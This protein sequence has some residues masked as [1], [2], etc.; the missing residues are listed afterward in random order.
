MLGD[1]TVHGHVTEKSDGMAFEIGHD[2]HGVYTRTSRSEK[3]RRVGDYT[4]AAKAKFGDSMDPTI[5][6]HFDDI[7]HHLTSNPNLTKHLR[8]TGGSIK[9]ELYHRPQGTPIGP[10]HVRFV[11]TAYDT[12][13]MGKHGSFIVHSR[14]P[15]NAS[16]KVSHVHK[17]GDDNFKFDHDHV[18][19]DIHIPMHDLKERHAAINTDILHSRKKVDA[20]HKDIE[21]RKFESIK[22]EIHKRVAAHTAKVH[23]KWGPETEG[24]VIH[25]HASNPDAPRVKIVDGNFM[26]RKHATAKFVKEGMIEEGGNVH[27]GDQKTVPIDIKDRDRKA[28]DVQEFM[29][30]VNKHSGHKIFGKD[31]KSL[32]TGS[33]WTGS[34]VHMMNHKLSSHELAK[35]KKS[36]GDVDVM[37]PHHAEEHVVKAL[38]PGTKHG[39]F[40][41]QGVK[42]IGAQHSA[43]VKHE[44]GQHHQIDFEYKDHEHGEPT[45]FARWSQNSHLHDLKTG[46]KGVMH[47]H[48]LNSITS[49]HSTH[50]IIETTKRKAIHHEEGEARPHTFAPAYGLRQK[51]EPALDAAGKQRHEGGLPVFHE[52]KPAEV[53]Y[54]TDLH[55]IH[56]KLFHKEASPVDID[57]M[58]SFHGTADLMKKHLSHDQIHKTVHSFVNKLYGSDARPH[59]DFGQKD[60]AIDSLKNHFPDHFDAPMKQHIKASKDAF[61][62]KHKPI[63]IGEAVEHPQDKHIAM[64]AGRFTGPTVEHQKLIDNVLKQKVDHHYVFVMGPADH[65]KTTEKDP[66]TVHE[67][68]HHLKKLY[69]EHKHIFVPGTTVHTKTPASALSWIHFRHKDQAKHLHL[70][71]VAGQGEEGVEKNAGGSIDSYKHMVHRLNHTK[72]PERINDEGKKVGGDHRMDYKST[73]FVPQAR[74]NVSG[75]KLRK[76]AREHDHNDPKHV[77]EFKKM[78]HTGATHEHASEIMHQIKSFKQHITE[79]LSV[80]EHRRRMNRIQRSQQKMHQRHKVAATRMATT[81]V[82]QRRAN[83]AALTTFRNHALGSDQSYTKLSVGQKL[84]FDEI[85]KGKKE[86]IA[87]LASSLMASGKQRQKEHDR[88]QAAFHTGPSQKRISRLMRS[89]NVASEAYELVAEEAK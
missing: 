29:H 22:D 85:M 8:H 70:H 68:I 49:A 41:V 67:K 21:K 30:S 80:G 37:V 39:K 46:L 12:R 58:H 44:D 18:D 77:S 55:S 14:L 17:L 19:H 6:K 73:N 59:E 5:S 20:E 34:T 2:E 11:G 38:Q 47:K 89:Y 72:F 43:V 66:L 28:K 25:P 86:A 60:H 45:K 13:K 27:I 56:K 7:H 84:W 9:G 1:G 87:R 69:P 50:G 40:T 54:D 57:S 82:L 81:S 42:K 10:H 79:E 31:A 15:E 51:H 24:H 64:A 88:L 33:A 83:H 4:K 36:F 23:P 32:K 65:S 35:H 26:A 48:L 62:A 71:V 75:S 3:M 52:H 16:L 53:K 61:V 74:G 76:F 63:S 78:L